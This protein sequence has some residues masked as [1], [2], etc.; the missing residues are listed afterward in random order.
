MKCGV[1]EWIWNEN[2]LMDIQAIL[3]AF[4]CEYKTN[5]VRTIQQNSKFQTYFLDI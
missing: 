3:L 4:K 1:F 2:G 5:N